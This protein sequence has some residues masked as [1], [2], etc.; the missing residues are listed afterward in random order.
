V[1]L[2]STLAVHTIAGEIQTPGVYSPPQPKMIA[3]D[4]SLTPIESTDTQQSGVETSDYL[5]YEALVALL[6]VY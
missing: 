2:V 5:F 1:L 3:I 6:S 4:E